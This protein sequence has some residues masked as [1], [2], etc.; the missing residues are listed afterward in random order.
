VDF[1]IEIPLPDELRRSMILADAIQSLGGAFDVTALTR[2]A[3]SNPPAGPWVDLVRQTKGLS[4]RALRHVLVLAATC[5]VHSQTLDLGHLRQAIDQMHQV[6]QGLI[7]EGGVYIESYQGS[8]DAGPSARAAIE[9]PALPAE[10]EERVG[11]AYPRPGGV[12][13]DDAS[14]LGAEIASLRDEVFSMREFL[15]RT[16]TVREI[17]PPALVPA[18]NHARKKR[19]GR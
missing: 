17:D 8:G 15:N 5:A 1:S 16:L 9:S 3:M 11:D 7:A 2:M 18:E 4:G 13:A 10:A 19:F 12:A 14:R 6:E